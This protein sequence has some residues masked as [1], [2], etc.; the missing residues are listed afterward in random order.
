[1]IIRLREALG[2][3]ANNAKSL[4]TASDEL[5]AGAYHTGQATNQIT[6]TIQQV[7]RGTT[8][9]TESITKTASS[10][11]QLSNA[12][13]GVAKGAQEQSQ[14]INQVVD[15][16]K[17]LSNGIVKVGQGAQLQADTI[18]ENQDVLEKLSAAMSEIYAGAMEQSGGLSQASGAAQELSQAF[19]HV[20]QAT[21]LVTEEVGKSALTASNGAI[22]V[23]N[24]S[25]G[26]E[27][28]RNAT[29]ALAKRVK[30]LGVFTGQIGA[31]VDTIEDIASQTNL[32]ALNAAI[33][34]ARA[35]EH[36]RGFAVVADE[37]R[38][39]AEKSSNATREIGEIV[40]KVQSGVGD[41]VS[42][43]KQASQ[44]VVIAAEATDKAHASFEAIVSGTSASTERGRIHQRGFTNYGRSAPGVG[45]VRSKRERDRRA[46]P[47]SSQ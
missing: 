1:M 29:E 11:E 35:G 43:M 2:H 24:T 25:K 32:L 22:A 39:L 7:A 40:K 4:G 20:S 26:M 21:E 17:D 41:A 38:K 8:Q 36:G 15:V 14:A 6:V 10:I 19:A 23:R 31:I 33:E 13:D 44:E 12:I 9:Q 5:S 45:Q 16:M 30:E 18:A 47:E 3:I 42:A 37:V 46:Q 28:V 27:Q 34:A